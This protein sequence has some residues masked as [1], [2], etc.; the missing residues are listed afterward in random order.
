LTKEY[1]DNTPKQ[2]NFAGFPSHDDAKK[3]RLFSPVGSNR[4]NDTSRL[5]PTVFY[6]KAYQT[7]KGNVFIK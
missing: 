2:E 7:G 1:E 6:T 3:K 4:L 5:K